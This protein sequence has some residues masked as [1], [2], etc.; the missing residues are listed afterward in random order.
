MKI[1]LSDKKHNPLLKRQEIT[2]TVQ[3]DGSTCSNQQL[4]QELS[5]SLKCRPELLLVEHI[6][7]AFGSTE[8]TFSALRYDDMESRKRATPL[9][10]HMKQK[11]EEERKKAEEERKQAKEKKK[12]E[13]KEEGQKQAAEKKN[14]EEK[15]S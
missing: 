5:A 12:A 2:G 6:Y 8:G 3:F 4:Q 9:T 10:K 7:T 15:S 14:V 11:L 1:T 13:E